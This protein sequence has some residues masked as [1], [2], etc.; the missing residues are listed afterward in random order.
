METKHFTVKDV[1][2]QF[3][4]KQWSSYTFWIV[5]VS[6]LFFLFLIFS[7]WNKIEQFL[8]LSVENTALESW[9]VLGE[10]T[11]VEGILTQDGDFITHTH[12][13]STLTS[14][15]F[16][17]KSKVINLNQYSGTVL[18]E[19]IVDTQHQG[20]YI[21]DVTKIIAQFWDENLTGDV[22]SWSIEPIW[23][24]Y[25]EMGL[26]L[27][28]SFFEE[29]TVVSQDKNSFTVKSLISNRQLTVDYF[30]CKRGDANRD[31]KQL[32]STFSDANEKTF[33]TKYGSTFYKLAEVNSWFFANQ[34]LF[35][36]FINNASEQEVTKLASY[37]VLPTLDYV[38]DTIEPK[39]SSFCKQG[40]VAMTSIKTTKMFLDQWKPAVH[41]VWTWEKWTLECKITLDLAL[42]SLWTI[43]SFVFKEDTMTWTISSPVQQ[44]S[45]EENDLVVDSS[46]AQFP[47]NV[48]KSLVFTSSRGHS[49]TFPSPKISYKSDS[50]SDNLGVGWLN[51]YVATKVIEYAKKDLIDSEPSVIVYECKVKDSV[52]I[53]AEY[54]AIYLSD[55]RAFLVSVRDGAW[56]TFWNNIQVELN[57]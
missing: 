1:P 28:P 13:L 53:P 51:C 42:P 23:E 16:W 27:S 52:A 21:I 31:C 17:L 11:S 50:I 3:S 49:I 6:V 19:W 57:Q 10:E 48:D 33:T 35:G 38:K 5:F 39:I 43:S 40:N 8:W 56:A 25:P 20:L 36:Y 44:P 34:E 32:S 22:V 7:K 9:F 41:F 46:V 15:V 26:Y 55:G 30:A 24:Y 29:Y 18:V 2:S 47:I 4:H 45:Q 54:R 12:K 14:G 37:L